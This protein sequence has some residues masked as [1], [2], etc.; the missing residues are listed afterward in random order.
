M[1]SHG[2]SRLYDTP[3]LNPLRLIHLDH[4]SINSNPSSPV[5]IDIEV[6]INKFNIDTIAGFIAIRYSPIFLTNRIHYQTF[7]VTKRPH[8]PS[9]PISILYLCNMDKKKAREDIRRPIVFLSLEGP[10]VS[11]TIHCT[12]GLTL[13]IR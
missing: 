4:I 2:E 13:A 7:G 8:H 6:S 3:G 1:H 9:N 10:V 11:C 12:T 5:L